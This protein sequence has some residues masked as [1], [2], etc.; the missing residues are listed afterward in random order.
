MKRV[1]IDCFGNRNDLAP[2]RFNNVRGEKRPCLVD[3]REDVTY[4]AFAR[5]SCG[6]Q[7]I[8]RITVVDD[9]VTMI[10]WA[11]GSWDNREHL[12]YENGMQDVMT[13]T[14]EE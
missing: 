13:I 2:E 4:M 14:V 11:Y 7:P 6:P 10:L 3:T 8:H 5:A 1:T 12:V 9:N